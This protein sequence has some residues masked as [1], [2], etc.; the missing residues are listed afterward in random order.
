MYDAVPVRVVKKERSLSEI[1]AFI[2]TRAR[3][4]SVFKRERDPHFTFLTEPC[5]D[6]MTRA[7]VLNPSVNPQRLANPRAL[8]HL[9]E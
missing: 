2:M 1:G 8:R 7:C 9:I 6:I 4:A 3:S 5:G